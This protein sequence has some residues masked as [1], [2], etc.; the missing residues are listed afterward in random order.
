M[1]AFDYAASASTAGRLLTQFGR[2]LTHTKKNNGTLNP[3]TGQKA[4][5]SADSTQSIV[6]V[7][8]PIS[9]TFKMDLIQADDSLKEDLIKGKVRGVFIGP[10][11]PNGDSLDFEPDV[12]HMINIDGYQWRIVGVSPLKPA[13]TVVMYRAAVRR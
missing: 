8:L 5:A 13:A 1:T 10:K 6:V 9:S 2:T 12:D 11:K 3:A 4:G 7:V